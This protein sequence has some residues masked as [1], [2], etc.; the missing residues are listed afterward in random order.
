MIDRM[1]VVVPA[2]DEEELLPACLESLHRSA[3]QTRL[4]VEVVVVADSCRDATARVAT[5]AGVRVVRSSA[6]RVGAA[7]ALGVASGLRDHPP[8]GT[9][10][11]STDADS[12]VPD[13]WLVHQFE[14]ATAGAD[15]VLGV[16]ELS[17]TP[18]GTE[19]EQGWL[20]RYAEGIDGSTH[21][22]VHGANLGVHASAYLRCGGFPDL[23]AHEDAALAAA[24]S[25]LPGACV[26]R[27]VSCPVRT[28][29]RRLGRAPAGVAHDLRSA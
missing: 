27:S 22:H 8:A 13:C 24:V 23:P 14:H 16:V 28:S 4:A 26:V 25:A 5:D 12:V 3:S 29:G 18:P 21:R 9:W 17:Q 10:I 1:V 7:R 15:L 19:P 2:R 6:G 20:T 11:A